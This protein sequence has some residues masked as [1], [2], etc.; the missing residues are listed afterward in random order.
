MN[1]GSRRFAKL[2]KLLFQQILLAPKG[3][4]PLLNFCPGFGIR[5]FKKSLIVEPCFML[6]EMLIN[7]RELFS[8]FLTCDFEVVTI[9]R[10]H[11]NVA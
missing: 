9:G 11:A 3:F 7:F 4:T 10:R 8:Q 5:L 2:L 6:N 1:E